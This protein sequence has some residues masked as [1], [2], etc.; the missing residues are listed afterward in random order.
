MTRKLLL[1]LGGTLA[2]WLVSGPIA[3]QLWGELGLIDSIVALGVCAVPM[4]M[5]LVV[6]HLATLSARPHDQVAAAF[7]GTGLR[8]MV[9]ILAGVGLFS[10]VPQLNHPGFLL[11]VVGYY[12][13]TL[14][15]EV[16]ILV[17]TAK[18]TSPASPAR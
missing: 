16:G 1:F 6:A 3:W 8:M 15:L 10:S 7:G 17:G 18:S 14:T 2:I 11:A 9:A 4:A 5:T 12:L 13:A